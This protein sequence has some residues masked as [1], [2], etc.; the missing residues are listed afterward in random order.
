VATVEATGKV[1]A[2]APRLI[3]NAVLNDVIGGEPVG[4]L[5]TLGGPRRRLLGPSR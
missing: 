5:L 4:R 3:G 2:Y 1:T